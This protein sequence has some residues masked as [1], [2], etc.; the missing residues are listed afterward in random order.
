[1]VRRGS[2]SLR[3]RHWD[4]S[5]GLT[6]VVGLNGAGKTTLLKTL[7]GIQRVTSG[8]VSG[9][10]NAAFLPQSA[11]LSSRFRVDD[12]LTYLATLRGVPSAERD[13]RVSA[14]VDQTGLSEHRTMRYSALSGG[15]QQRVLL[16]QCLLG[17][18]GCVLLD[19]PTSSLDIAATREL[20]L[21]LAELSRSRPFVVS[22]HSASVALEF[23]DRVVPIRDGVVHEPHDG[24][25]LRADY[26]ASELSPEAYLLDVLGR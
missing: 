2:F 5:P 17:D 1:M 16:A 23:A 22:T 15:W 25:Q 10:G 21:V 7:A 12:L 3:C 9:V 13:A 11:Q 4:E 24:A 19:E 26:A 8:R 6:V 20:W 18:A 14:V